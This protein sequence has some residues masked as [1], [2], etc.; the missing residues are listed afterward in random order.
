MRG[1]NLKYLTSHTTM[2]NGFNQLL[3]PVFLMKTGYEK[4]RSSMQQ[5]DVL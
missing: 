2:N 5:F 1:M 3:D 4:L